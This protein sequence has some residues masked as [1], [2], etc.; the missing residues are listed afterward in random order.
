LRRLAALPMLPVSIRAARKSRSRNLRR[1]LTRSFQGMARLIPTS[2]DVMPSSYYSFKSTQA[3]IRSCSHTT[4]HGGKRGPINGEDAMDRRAFLQAAAAFGLGAVAYEPAR[5]Q[6]FPSNVFRIVVPY[7]P[8][9]PPDILARVVA[10]VLADGEGW[11]VIVENKPG[12]VGTIGA[13]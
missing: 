3:R 11:N 7:S 2:Y 1:R 12:A 6:S 10:T 9:T 8:S 4:A 5:G 13:A